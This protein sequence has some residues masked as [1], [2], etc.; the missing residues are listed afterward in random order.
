MNCLVTPGTVVRPYDPFHKGHV[1][2]GKCDPGELDDG[3]VESLR[4][5]LYGRPEDI[6]DEGG[7]VYKELGKLR[8]LSME[9]SEGSDSLLE[10]EQHV[11]QRG[12]RHGDL[13]N[14]RQCC[15]DLLLRVDKTL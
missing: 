7:H 8:E 9:Q 2:T 5:S 11:L 13:S 1:L 4:P 14:L 3:V 10:N 15:G 12:I 6:S